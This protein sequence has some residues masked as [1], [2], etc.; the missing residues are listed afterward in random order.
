MEQIDFWSSNKS[1]DE[2]KLEHRQKIYPPKAVFLAKDI[3]TSIVVSC[4]NVEEHH[5]Q[6]SITLGSSMLQVMLYR[7][8]YVIKC[9]LYRYR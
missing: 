2:M 8:D 4:S 6:M 3:P 1:F 9:Y 5:L 7:Y